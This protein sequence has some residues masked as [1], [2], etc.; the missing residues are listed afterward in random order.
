MQ[1]AG[2]SGDDAFKHFRGSQSL[3]ALSEN[4]GL[5]LRRLKRVCMLLIKHDFSRPKCIGHQTLSDGWM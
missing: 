5:F 2:N 4:F 1:G 3:A